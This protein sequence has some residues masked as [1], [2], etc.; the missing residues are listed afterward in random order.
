MRLKHGDNIV[1]IA[2]YDYTDG[3]YTINV[4]LTPNWRNY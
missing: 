1:Y 2:G 3:D 4:S